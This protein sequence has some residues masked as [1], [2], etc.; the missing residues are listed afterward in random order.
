[1]LKNNFNF[2]S[3]FTVNGK[4]VKSIQDLPVSVQKLFEDKD[5]NGIPDVFEIKS[6]KDGISQLIR[7]NNQ[8]YK[9]WKDVPQQFQQF[10]KLSKLGSNKQNFKKIS[11]SKDLKTTPFI[12]TD[13]NIIP[14]NDIFNPAK[15]KSAINKMQFV[16]IGIVAVIYF[17][18]V[19]Y[20]KK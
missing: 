7:I 14:L 10:K 8:V 1:M 19:Y 13:N 4:K 16:A 6:F 17:I 20:L 2:K 18:Y 3:N 12:K 5:D 15:I 9:N 11:F